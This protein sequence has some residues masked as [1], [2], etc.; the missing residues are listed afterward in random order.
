MLATAVFMTVLRPRPRVTGASTGACTD[1]FTGAFT[2]GSMEAAGVGRGLQP[3]GVTAE[4][5]HAA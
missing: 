3:G 1:A 5:L 4:R 2:D